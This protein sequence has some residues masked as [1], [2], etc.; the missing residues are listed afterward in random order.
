MRI[1]DKTARVLIDLPLVQA[2][3]LNVPD[4]TRALQEGAFDP[5]PDGTHSGGALAQNSGITTTELAEAPLTSFDSALPDHIQFAMLS[6]LHGDDT[7]LRDFL[8]I[9]DRRLLA[10]EVRAR[11]ASMLVATQDDRGRAVASI[12][13]RL[14]RMVKRSPEDTRYLKLLMPLLSRTRSLE[15]LREMLGWWTGS[16]VSVSAKFDTLRPIDSDSL[17]VLTACRHSAVALGRGALLGRFGRTPMGHISVRI[18]CANRAELN[19]LIGDTQGLAELRSVT[20]QYLRDPVPVSFYATIT[21]RCLEP[22]RLS[23]RP[24]RADRLGAYN[25]LRP[26]HRPNA[27]ASIKLT[28]IF[29]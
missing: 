9:F 15:G 7:G 3:R 21:R 29:A 5:Y 10:L 19:A 23:A 11:R 27:R 18:S 20:G 16:T 28:E 22:P 25:L 2:E 6:A 1:K 14:L 8:A 24:E 17:S 4:Y 12:L 13:S 26:E